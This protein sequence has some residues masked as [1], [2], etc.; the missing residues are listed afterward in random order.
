MTETKVFLRTTDK[1]NVSQARSLAPGESG[2][3][4]SPKVFLKSSDMYFIGGNGSP[5]E[6]IRDEK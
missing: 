2:M 5:R 1:K 4:K 6:G 3:K